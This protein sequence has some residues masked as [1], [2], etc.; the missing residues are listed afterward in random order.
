MKLRLK[1]IADI[2]PL[3]VPLPHGTEVTTRVDRMVGDQMIKQGAVGRVSSI[4]KGSIV[5]QIV[6]VGRLFELLENA[7]EKSPLPKESPDPQELED[8]LIGVRRQN[9]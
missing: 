7:L 8:W 6:G 5:V 2:D 9:L 3:R 4:E 1:H